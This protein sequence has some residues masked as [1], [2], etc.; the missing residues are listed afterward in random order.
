VTNPAESIE[1]MSLFLLLKTIHLTCAILSISGFLV[2]GY[3][4][5]TG[6]PLLQ[7]RVT[8]ILPHL[9]DTIL[10]VSAVWM[11]IIIQQFPFVNA[12][13]TAK[14]MALVV[15]IVFGTVALK[16]GKT[17]GIRTLSLFGAVSVFFY[18]VAVA[19]AHD[20]LANLVNIFLRQSSTG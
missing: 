16:R 14:L 2:R 9:V 6:S 7:A 11:T 20:P 5:L 3:W 13:L 17:K 19:L 10:L 4:M 18:I 15:Y 8:K 12:W 1:P